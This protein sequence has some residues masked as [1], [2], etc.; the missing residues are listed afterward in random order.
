MP[1]DES[2]TRFNSAFN[3]AIL[4]ETKAGLCRVELREPFVRER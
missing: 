2:G 1:V 4:P 3:S